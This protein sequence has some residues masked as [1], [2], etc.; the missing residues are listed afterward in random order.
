MTDFI[1]RFFISNIVIGLI[2]C[3]LLASRRLLRL[4]DR[5][6]YHLWFLLLG[7]LTVPFLPLG[8]IRIPRL[9][10]LSGAWNSPSAPRALPAEGAAAA[11]GAL[12]WMNDFS[13]SAGSRMPSCAG[14]FLGILWA[15]G[16]LFAGIRLLRSAAVLHAV[17]K[18]ALPLQNPH[19]GMVYQNCLK[20][21][22]IRRRIPISSSAF[23]KS[24]MITGLFLPQIYLPIQLAEDFRA[25]EIRYMLLHEL[26]HYKHRDALPNVWMNLACILYWFNPLVRYALR[27]MQTDREIACDASVLQMLRREEYRNYGSTLLRYAEQI[28][29]APFPL[30]AGLGGSMGQ[31]ERRIRNIVGY[32]PVSLRKKLRSAAAFVCTCLLLSAF[33][34]AL[35]AVSADP[36]YYVFEEDDSRIAYVDYSADFKD[37]YGSFVLYDADR[38]QWMIYNRDA[39]LRRVPPAS[40]YKIYAA[41]HALESG[42]ITP[43]ASLLPWNGLR[44]PYDTWNADQ[45]LESAM[46]DSVTWYFQTLD[47]QMGLE[48][49]REFIRKIGYGN[50]LAEGDA[51]TYWF[52]SSLKI[53]PVEQVELLQKFHEGTLPF[54]SENVRTVEDSIRL[55]VTEQGTLYGKTGTESANGRNFSGWFVGYL[56]HGEGTYYFATYMQKDD[57]ASGTAAAE[58]TLRILCELGIWAQ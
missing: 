37:T 36:G 43:G 2:I 52:N 13:L 12:D 49:I 30:T 42:V 47:R 8:T 15:A 32:Q 29:H 28:S 16:I 33:L 45:T 1:I 14:T 40:T 3:I 38:G 25:G 54:S 11:S 22:K 58:L 44:Y 51:D 48:S 46:T 9:L 56:E 26:Q 19:I 18:S 23:L 5:T 21:M 35:S 34:P 31:M 27:E 7:A 17:K 55:S 6:R 10:S 57:Y 20:E 41:L 53:S 50:R 39:A 24:P 4:T